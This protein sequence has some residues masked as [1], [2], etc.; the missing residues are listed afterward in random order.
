MFD[1]EDTT[2][3]TALPIPQDRAAVLLLDA[4]AQAL[5]LPGLEMMA[6]EHRARIAQ[7]MIIALAQVHRH[8]AAAQDSAQYS[9]QADHLM[10]L[11]NFWRL[12]LDIARIERDRTAPPPGGQDIDA[13]LL[14]KL[15]GTAIAIAAT[16]DAST[17]AHLSG[18]DVML[19]AR[20]PIASLLH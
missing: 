20:A 11:M 19:S 4:Q 16:L 12:L 9:A 3:A 10:Q 2:Q 15:S 5:A 6:G 18:L 1:V 8:R 14:V 13:A 17:F 7:G